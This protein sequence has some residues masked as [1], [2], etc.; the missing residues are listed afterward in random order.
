LPLALYHLSDPHAWHKFEK[1]CTKS[2]PSQAGLH[3][4]GGFDENVVMNSQVVI[5]TERAEEC[6]SRRMILLAGVEQCV[7]A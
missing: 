1:E 3:Q 5:R 4:G 7:K 2:F 6:G